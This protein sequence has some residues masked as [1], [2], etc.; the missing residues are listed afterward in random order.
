MVEIN[1]FDKK[2]SSENVDWIN[3]FKVAIIEENFQKIEELSS[4]LPRFIVYKNMIE[5]QYL[6]KEA[7]VL[8]YKEK[9]QTMVKMQKLKLNR[10]F[11]SSSYTGKISAFDKTS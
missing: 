8:M 10:Q 3:S 5:A 7:L 9:Q 4:L 6:I 11:I 1:T 2:E